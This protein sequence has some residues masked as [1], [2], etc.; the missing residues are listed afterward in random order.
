MGGGIPNGAVGASVAVLIYS[1]LCLTCSSLVVGLLLSY[2]EK[3][4]CKLYIRSLN[5]EQ[6]LTAYLIDVTFLCFF[7]ALSTVASII[8]QFHYAFAWEVIK[9]AQ[10]NQAVQSLTTPALGL[11]G[12]AQIVDVV[13]FDIRTLN[14]C[15]NCSCRANHAQNFI[16]TM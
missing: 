10:F 8:Q 12:A 11:G 6:K 5:L 16:A 2:G 15:R 13:L 4:T 14:W 7:T 3:W 9:Q 1:F